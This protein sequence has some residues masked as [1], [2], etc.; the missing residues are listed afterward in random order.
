V[1]RDRGTAYHQTGRGMTETL[2]PVAASD[3]A[4]T[5]DEWYTPRWL[6]KAAG[7]TFDM[8][9]CA[10]VDA[11]FRTCP[12]R[13]YLTV[14]DDGLTAPWRGTVWMNPPYSGPEPW[15]RRWATHPDG[16]TLVPA[17]PRARSWR[18][19]L[20]PA[21]DAVMIISLKFGKADG[22]EQDILWALTLAARGATCVDALSRVAAADQSSGA[23]HVRPSAPWKPKPPGG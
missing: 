18:S 13:E 20:M 15:V 19:V 1:T 4:L 7:I 21:A 3:V 6:F 8:D 16:M 9:V 11:A 10:P 23:Y 14:L 17:L 5:S 2:F 12:A 22:Q